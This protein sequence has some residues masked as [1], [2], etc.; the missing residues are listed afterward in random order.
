MGERA[1]YRTS[2]Q[3]CAAI[4]TIVDETCPDCGSHLE[5]HESEATDL[6]DH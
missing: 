4:V 1:C 5:C 6:E 2:C 3:S